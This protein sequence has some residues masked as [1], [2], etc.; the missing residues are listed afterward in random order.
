VF[1]LY[2]ALVGFVV[3][4]F[5]RPVTRLRGSAELRERLG[6]APVP[7]AARPRI[8]LHAVSAGEMSAAGAIVEALERV[9][10]SAAVH[11]TAGNRDARAAGE[12]LRGSRRSIS[13]V[14]FLPWDRRR[15]IGKWLAVLDPD[16]VAV[17]ETE[18]W[19]NLFRACAGLG[20]PLVVVNGRIPDRDFPRY[21]LARPFF[22]RVLS[23]V[24]AIAAQSDLD[25]RRFLRIGAPPERVRNAGNV[26][27]D[28][29]GIG[30]S[31]SGRAAPRGPII[32]AGSTHPPE[33]RLLLSAFAR[34]RAEFPRLS[35]VLAPR[36]VGRAEAL[37]RRVR[38][39]GL[40]GARASGDDGTAEVVVVDVLGELRDRYVEE[41]IAVVGGTWS[42]AG[43]HT[44]LEAAARG[45]AVV[46]GPN[47]GNYRAMLADMLAAG[48]A[49][50]VS[51]DD[52]EG[53]LREL[54][55]E[56]AR[57]AEL[58]RRARA[59]AA[60]GRGAARRCAEEIA[61]AAQERR[62]RRISAPETPA[63]SLRNGSGDRGT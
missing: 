28:A 15:A 53:A 6:D 54:L 2:D 56:P 32:V 37:L 23:G 26:K 13:S 33:E 34:L 59:F 62:G 52:L 36:H 3:A 10:P 22:R 25:A 39:E 1:F 14:S 44:P 20:I 58:G 63:A 48:A 5:L 43:G 11:L 18:I 31:G 4:V 24:R 41:E 17:V 60:A 30:G 29:A 51:R 42:R 35:L 45:C 49:V 8:V 47:A 9:L 19:P 40:R 38:A 61:A 46:F 55:E 21:R 50:R 7:S 16:A 57:R 12:R 27:F